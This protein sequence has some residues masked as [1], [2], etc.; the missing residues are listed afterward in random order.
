VITGP[1]L[2]PRPLV[3]ALLVLL[4]ARLQRLRSQLLV[5]RQHQQ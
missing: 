2:L 4:Q 5:P 1:K 3:P